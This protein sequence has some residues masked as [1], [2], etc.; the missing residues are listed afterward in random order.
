MFLWSTFMRV[1]IHRWFPKSL[2]L[3]EFTKFHADFFKIKFF[4]LCEFSHPSSRCAMY[5]NWNE[6][7]IYLTFDYLLNSTPARWR[8]IFENTFSNFVYRGV[9][10]FIEGN[11]ITSFLFI[12][13]SDIE[14]VLTFTPK[15]SHLGYNE[16]YFI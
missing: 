13:S 6:A 9:V 7:N 3:W 10:L 8:K 1:C 16:I 11:K 5:R 14:K 4:H 12:F 2:T 15:S